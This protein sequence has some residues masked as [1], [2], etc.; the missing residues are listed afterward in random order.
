MNRKWRIMCLQ[1][2][3]VLLF[4]S[5]GVHSEPAA[6]ETFATAIP[7]AIETDNAAEVLTLSDAA[8]VYATPDAYVDRAFESIFQIYAATQDIDGMQGYYATGLVRDGSHNGLTLL[9]FQN[10]A[11]EF[12]EGEMIYLYGTV[13][14]KGIL[15]NDSGI[16]AEILMLQVSS[17]ERSAS[18]AGLF[19]HT[20]TWTPK[21]GSAA[22]AYGT[23][24][25]EV[26]SIDFKE[27]ETVL[28]TK[29]IDTG[30]T[31]QTTYYTD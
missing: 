5:C 20:E 2:V 22:A 26:T 23:L 3:M 1:F 21:P 7:A 17:C 4:T 8:A 18:E 10:N 29:T 19:T 31:A 25:I 11:P 28:S 15:K 14:G 13:L 27:N 24:S 30:V 9:L 16:S 6:V 12:A